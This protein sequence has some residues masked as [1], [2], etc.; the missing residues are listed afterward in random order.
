MIA[1]PRSQVYTVQ[2]RSHS[3]SWRVQMRSPLQC[4]TFSYTHCSTGRRAISSL[5]CFHINVVLLQAPGQHDNDTFSSYQSAS[6]TNCCNGDVFARWYYFF[7]Q[8][9]LPSHLI[10][11]LKCH[12]RCSRGSHRVC[13]M[14]LDVCHWHILSSLSLQS[15]RKVNLCQSCIRRFLGPLFLCFHFHH[16]LG[17]VVQELSTTLERAHIIV[18][19]LSYGIVR[20]KYVIGDLTFI[21]R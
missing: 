5:L 10:S 21:W 7:I 18:S 8:V 16:L 14:G 11:H 4:D 12:R 20:F 19:G 6:A 15:I 1:Q 9:Q 3:Q 17:L 13:D 2:G